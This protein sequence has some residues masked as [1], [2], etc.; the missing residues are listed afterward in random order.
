MFSF[1]H[2]IV[3]RNFVANGRN[4]AVCLPLRS[5]LELK[6]WRQTPCANVQQVTRVQS[7][8]VIQA[9]WSEPHIY[10]TIFELIADIVIRTTQSIWMDTIIIIIKMILADHRQRKRSKHYQSIIKIGIIYLNKKFGT[11]IE[12]NIILQ[13]AEYNRLQNSQWRRRRRRR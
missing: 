12:S 8:I 7:I 5:G 10:W 6:R 11:W 9:F 13:F 2:K 1:I 3:N 4:H